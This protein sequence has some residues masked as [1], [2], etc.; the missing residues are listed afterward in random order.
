MREELNK[1]ISEYNETKRCLEMGIEWLPENDFAKAK[2]DMLNVIIGDLEKLSKKE[3][4]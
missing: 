4:N 2:L 1:L 3:M